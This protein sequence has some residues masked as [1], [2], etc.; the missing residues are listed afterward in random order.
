[1]GNLKSF[2]RKLK[3]NSVAT[4]ITTMSYAD[5]LKKEIKKAQIL[6]DEKLLAD[7]QSI[8]PKELKRLLI[9]ECSRQYGKV[10]NQVDNLVR[11]FED[12]TIK[13]NIEAANKL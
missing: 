8:D 12:A 4:A 2:R 6:K 3:T 11:N 9:K 1:M 5:Q 13:E 7:L 10:E